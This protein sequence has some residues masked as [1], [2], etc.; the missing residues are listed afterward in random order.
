[1]STRR[2]GEAV[3]AALVAGAAVVLVA[4]A[5]ILYFGSTINPVHMSP[6]S[7]P[8]APADVAAGRYVAAVE[9]AQRLARALLVQE[10]L[11]GLSVAVAVDGAVVW[12]EGF[13]YAAEDRTPVTPI[14]RFR[15]G[16]LSKPMTAVAAALLHDQ[17]RLDLDAPVQRYVP[18][19]P[20]KQWTVTTRQLMGD[21]AGVHRGRG[22]NIDGDSMPTQ[23]CAN[24]DEA[25]ELFAGDQLRFEPGTQHRYSIFGWVL[26]SAVVERAAKEPFARFMQRQVF[27]PLGMDR[28]VVEEREGID[29][30]TSYTPRAI[31]RTRLG[32]KEDGPPD[33]SCLAGAGAF[34]STPTDLVR[35]GSAVLKPGL[36]KAEA[37]TSLQTPTRLASGAS[38]TYAL[39]WTVGSVQLAGRPARMVSHRG[40]PRGG[41]VSLLTFPDLGLTV[42]AAANMN[43]TSV[44]RFAL[45]V[46]DA[47]ARH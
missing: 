41:T 4:G 45:Q 26:V 30:A 1:M 39:G 44:N 27:E 22:D 2:R 31:L 6:A 40:S 46:A 14:T 43:V 28:T 42:A 37:I 47:F 25:V 18:A 3:I 11:P 33:Y 36:L 16:A 12:A 8:S 34:L 20:Q 23:H 13:G 10:N 24:L 9:E 17:G 38:T 19:Y 5:G 21:V 32:I 15:L 29:D 35:L 7:I